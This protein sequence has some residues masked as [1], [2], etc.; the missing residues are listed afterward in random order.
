YALTTKTSSNS[1]GTNA[2]GHARTNTAKHGHQNYW[3]GRTTRPLRS[4]HQ[5]TTATRSPVAPATAHARPANVHRL[6]GPDCRSPQPRENGPRLHHTR[7]GNP[8]R[9]VGFRPFRSGRPRSPRARAESF[10]GFRWLDLSRYRTA[11]REGVA[12]GGRA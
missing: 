4:S 2:A 7:M 9:H 3:L 5:R 11:R 6:P 8:G 1:W 12:G 10:D